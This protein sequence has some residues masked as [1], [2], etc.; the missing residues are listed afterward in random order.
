MPHPL[1]EM[2]MSN[3][4]SAAP[5]AS[6]AEILRWRTVLVVNA[7]VWTLMLASLWTAIGNQAAGWSL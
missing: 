2:A 5:V 7:L 1:W 3:P 4:Q 6:P